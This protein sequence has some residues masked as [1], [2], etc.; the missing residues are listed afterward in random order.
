MLPY[1][2]SFLEDALSHKLLTPKPD[3]APPEE[4]A[5]E[6]RADSGTG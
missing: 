1:V 6:P 2:F 3:V 4:G 5:R